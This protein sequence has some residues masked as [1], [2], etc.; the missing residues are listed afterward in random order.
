MSCD[1][2]DCSTPMRVDLT[3]AIKK[4]QRYSYISP[5][6][7]TPDKIIPVGEAKIEPVENMSI[8]DVV[9]LLIEGNIQAWKVLPASV[10]NAIIER[11]QD[12]Q[13]IPN[14]SIKS[15]V[16]HDYDILYN[17][18]LWKYEHSAKAWIISDIIR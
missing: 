7:I 10:R 11:P 1:D 2:D 8:K 9:T 5:D 4:I 17:G 13:L 3:S 12:F 6:R 15:S 14:K 18:T 16:D